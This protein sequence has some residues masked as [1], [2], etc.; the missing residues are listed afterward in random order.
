MPLLFVFLLSF[1]FVSET[2]ITWTTPTEY[3]FGEILR[4]G[5]AI[6]VFT[7]KNLTDKPIVVDNVRT[8]CS[9]TAS[10]WDTAPI[11]PKETGKI[12]VSYDSKKTGYFRKKLTVWISGQHKP[13]K[14]IIE[15]EVK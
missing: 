15:G 13:E 11:L 2:T 3:D 6:H 4:G 8:D 14:L 1:F 5:E 9:C 10:D 12:T 7:F